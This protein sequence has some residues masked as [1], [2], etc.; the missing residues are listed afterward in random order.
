[1]NN[2]NK[3][4]KNGVMKIII[5]ASIF[6]IGSGIAGELFSRS[7]IALNQA[8]FLN[9]LNF[10][11]GNYKPNLVI[12]DA[13]KVIVEQDFKAA[14]VAESA[15]AGIVGIFKKKT[16]GKLSGIFSADDYYHL[17]Q[18]SGQGLIITSDGWIAVA[19]PAAAEKENIDLL[20]DY[21]A[22]SR[23]KKLYSIDR[24]VKDSLTGFYFAHI[25]TS[26]LSVKE[27]AE[28]NEIQNGKTVEAVNWHKHSQLIEISGMRTKTLEIVFS[29]DDFNK[30]IILSGDLNKEFRGSFLFSLEG[31]VIGM[32]NN[33]GKALPITH[34]TSAISSLLKIKSVK[35]ASLG[36]NY[37]DLAN[38]IPVSGA[39]KEE[40]AKGAVI[41]KNKQK[42]A[43]VKESAAAKAG[44]KEGDIILLVNNIEIGPANSLA[45]VI[46]QYIAG[47][48]IRIEYL[49]GS[50]RKR[51]EVILGELK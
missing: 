36:M 20:K 12:R 9:E 41:Y 29:S 25:N 28:R 45:D 27:F 51:V 14:E 33:E 32:I 8:P 13:K 39:V 31:K 22:V 42:I 3:R 2:E 1:M 40:Y 49:R 5:L 11:D 38:L 7:Y 46:Q 30:E 10:T 26:G 17:N 18:I 4:T 15:S 44:L 34:F 24:A 19:L 43:I 6:G 23:D 50:E 37:I 16:I 21:V 35:R 47:D 48:K